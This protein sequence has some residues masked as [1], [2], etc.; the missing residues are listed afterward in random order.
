MGT[1]RIDSK[2]P[3]GSTLEGLLLFP[4]ITSTQELELTSANH[5]EWGYSFWTPCPRFTTLQGLASHHTSACE[6]PA[7]RGGTP[8]SSKGTF[9]S[10]KG[11]VGTSPPGC[12]KSS[13]LSGSWSWSC[14]FSLAQPCLVTLPSWPQQASK[15]LKK[16]LCSSH[17]CEDW[18]QWSLYCRPEK[19]HQF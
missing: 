6:V 18:L 9:Q 13:D 3:T 4:Q 12:R 15:P 19:W 7:S 17:S 8:A 11:W 5:S 1:A 16:C 2:E 10:R 14:C